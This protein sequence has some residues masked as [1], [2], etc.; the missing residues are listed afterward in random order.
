M[1]SWCRPLVALMFAASAWLSRSLRCGARVT[2]SRWASAASQPVWWL[3]LTYVV[4]TDGNGWNVIGT[5]GPVAI[6]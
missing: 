1:T 5:T 6:S 3:W 4:Q 2:A